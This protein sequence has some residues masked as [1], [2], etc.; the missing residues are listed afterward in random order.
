MKDLRFN[1]NGEFKIIQFTDV[2][3]QQG[4]EDDDKTLSLME[5]LLAQENPDLAAFTGDMVYLEHNDEALRKALEPVKK[6]GI[7]FAPVFG[8]H[9]SEIGLSREKLALV[10]NEYE[11][12]L[13]QK[14]EDGVSGVGNYAVNIFDKN[15]KARWSLYFLDSNSYNVN[16]LVGGYDFIKRDQIDWYVNKA[17]ETKKNF[18]HVPALAFFHMPLPE[19][20][21]VWDFLRCY[22]EKNE[23]VSCPRQNSGLFSAMLEMGNVKGVFVG[24]DHIND[25]WGQLCG[26]NLYFGRATGYDTYGK[27]GYRHGARI[28][29][30]SENSEDLATYIRLDNGT[31][32]HKQKIHEPEGR[33][34][35]KQ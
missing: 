6:S 29:V 5:N 9:D 18:G 11:N 14:G 17:N 19:Y 1:K 24:H 10:F 35:I 16:E 30:L 15:D 25:Y 28:I 34:V 26:I 7:P 20:N 22:G 12:S 4:T 2:H 33:K 31:I 21:D 8:N 3:F 32:I 13:F 27:E 23:E